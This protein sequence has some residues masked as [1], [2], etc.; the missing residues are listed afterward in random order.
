MRRV[1]IETKGAERMGMETF[2]YRVERDQLERLV[3]DWEFFNS[4]VTNQGRPHF[5]IYKN[6]FIIAL[7]LNPAFMGHPI[8]SPVE[9]GALISILLGMDGEEIHDDGPGAPG[10]IIQTILIHTAL[11]E[12]EQLEKEQVKEHFAWDVVSEHCHIESDAYNDFFEEVVWTLLMQFKTFLA[13]TV[14]ADDILVL[15]AM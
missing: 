5:N 14:E 11:Q 8:E 4:A 6:A 1:T 13:G 2:F 15:V 9:A 3:G 12:L 10:I 7:G